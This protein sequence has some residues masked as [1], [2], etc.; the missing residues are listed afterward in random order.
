LWKTH[1]GLGERLDYLPANLSGGQKQRVAIAR[2]LVSNPE[3]ILADEPTANLDEQSTELVL[4]LL[5]ELSEA[6]KQILILVTHERDVASTLPR[7]IDL[8]TINK[9]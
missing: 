1:H 4:K 7:S 5:N 2:A 3:I 8:K 9:I 6:G